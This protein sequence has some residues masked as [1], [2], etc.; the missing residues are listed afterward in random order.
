[1]RGNKTPY[2]ICIRFCTL[3]DIPD[4][5]IYANFGD[6]RFRGLWV[7]EGQSL[8]FSIDFDRLP[9]ECVMMMVTM[10]MLL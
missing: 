7:A 1:M 4:I 8:P 10:T 2:L 9:C 3:V 5:I 6:D